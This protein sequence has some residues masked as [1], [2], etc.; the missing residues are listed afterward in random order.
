MA[1]TRAGEGGGVLSNAGQYTALK[2]RGGREEGGK[3]GNI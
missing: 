3:G 1:E 2:K